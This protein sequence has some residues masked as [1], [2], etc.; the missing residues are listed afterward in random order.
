LIS[1]SCLEAAVYDRVPDL[2]CRLDCPPLMEAQSESAADHAESRAT[3]PKATQEE[4]VSALSERVYVTFT[5]LA[6]LLAFGAEVADAS[7]WKVATALLI[8]IVGA[9]FAGFVSNVI[10]RLAVTGHMPE[11]RVM[12]HFVATSV[13]AVLTAVIPLIVLA[14]AGFKIISL[15]LA[16]RL[17]AGVLA[18]SLGGIAYLAVRRSSLKLSQKIAVFAAELVFA[19]AVIAVELS[20]HD[21][22]GSN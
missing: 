19:V 22:M 9:A 7:A 20:A 8:G 13:G 5:G 1:S 17:S 3:K 15:E 4:L 11:R 2:L 14:L 6:V 10:S 21:V 18:L 12:L 16:V